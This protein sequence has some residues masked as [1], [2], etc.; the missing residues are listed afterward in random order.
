MIDEKW[1]K[2]CKYYQDKDKVLFDF[3]AKVNSEDLGMKLATNLSY[4]PL[5]D[6]FIGTSVASKINESEIEDLLQDYFNFDRA[7]ITGKYQHI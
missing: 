1:S 6:S 7:N 4:Y 3:S 2:I 5:K